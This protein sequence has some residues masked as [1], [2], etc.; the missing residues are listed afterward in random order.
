MDVATFR[1]AL[2]RCGITQGLARNSIVAQGYD[3]MEAFASLLANDRSV[4][5]FV[6]SVNKLP[7]EPNGDR[8]QIPFASIRRLQAMRH[9]TIERQRCGIAVVHNEFTDEEMTR[10]LE[11]MEE[12]ESI[13][14]TPTAAPPLPE[15]F[16]SFGLNWR[17]FSEGFKGHCAAIRG[18]MRIPLIYVLRSHTLVTPEQQAA[19]Y[20][21]ADERLMT[22]VQLQ[23]KEYRKDNNAVWQLLRP[24]VL[25]TPAWNY[26]KQYDGTQD[27]RTA[28]LALQTRGEGDAAEDA[29]RARAEQIIQKAQFTGKSKRFTISNYINLLQGAFTELASIGTG[30][31]A[32]TEKQKVSIFMRGL[33]AEEYAATKHSIYQNPATREDFQQ[34]YAFV[35][36]MEQF[37]MSYSDTTSYDR[38]IAETGTHKK[39]DG[40]YRSPQEWAAL[41][42]E[43]KAKILSAHSKK[44]GGGKDKSKRGDKN[45]KRKLEAIVTEAVEAIL[46]ITDPSSATPTVTTEGVGNSTS[47]ASATGSSPGDQFG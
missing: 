16:T 30:E 27:G 32:L 1:Q 37:K 38:N 9:W 36:T 43:E 29:R 22:L 12:E 10:I 18:T 8:P 20:S 40:S 19:Q 15:K 7:A 45:P 41:S 17:V 24:L 21:T 33:V 34:C 11:R 31:Y 23:G 42:K 5:D 26:V 28:F 4:T 14:E 13:T 35:Q 3:T 44:K 25:E 47:T 6:K 2:V 39:T 46:A